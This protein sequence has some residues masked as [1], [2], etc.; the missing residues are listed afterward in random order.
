M[1]NVELRDY[2]AG[3]AVVGA[4]VNQRLNSSSG[5]GRLEEA[6]RIA[7]TAYEIADALLAARVK[8]QPALPR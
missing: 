1:A 2:L 7:E 5:P 6:A 4:A 8:G 3:Q